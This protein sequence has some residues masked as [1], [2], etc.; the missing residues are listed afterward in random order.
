M[1]SFICL[2][3][4][5]EVPLDATNRWKCK[6]HKEVSQASQESA[7]IFKSIDFDL[8]LVDVNELSAVEKY[9]H[10][11]CLAVKSGNVS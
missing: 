5:N 8:L 1:H 7:N 11:I 6:Q 3:H 4:A 9:I 2:L 10:E